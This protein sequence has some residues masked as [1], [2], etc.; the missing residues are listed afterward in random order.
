V[1]EVRGAI[2]DGVAGG[3]RTEQIVLEGNAVTD[4]QLTEAFECDLAAVAGT[5]VPTNLEVEVGMATDVLAELCDEI[6][7]LVVGSGHTALPGRV[8]LGDTGR[9]MLP[10]AACPV[11]VVPRPAA[12]PRHGR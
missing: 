4:R 12:P 3:L 2:D 7:L 10:L 1:L 5:G 8:Q 9:G 11:L 6:D